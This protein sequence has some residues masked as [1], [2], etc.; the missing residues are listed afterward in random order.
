MEELTGTC[1]DEALGRNCWE[2]IGGTDLEGR[3]VC[4]PDCTYARCALQGYAMRR[5][6][7]LVETAWGK[8]YAGCLTVAVGGTD[9]PPLL[10][11]LI[12]GVA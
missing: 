1:P 11:H 3:A 4:T 6:G 5:A 12:R 9:P 7:V 10:L 8:R 2:V